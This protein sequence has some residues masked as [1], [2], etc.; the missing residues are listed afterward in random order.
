MDFIR[1]QLDRI[2]NALASIFFLLLITEGT[3]IA[4]FFKLDNGHGTLPSI[5]VYKRA[6]DLIVA[7]SRKYVNKGEVKTVSIPPS[8]ERAFYGVIRIRMEQG[9]ELRF[10]EAY[11]YPTL[12]RSIGGT[13]IIQ[14]RDMLDK[15]E[16]DEI[17]ERKNPYADNSTRVLSRNISYGD[18]R[19]RSLGNTDH[20]PPRSYT[21]PKNGSNPQ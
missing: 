16:R 3:L 4:M 5:K 20:S 11:W 13:S 17:L 8:L 21:V 6:F 1:E 15:A 19:R 14:L 10:T 2:L 7:R 12:W 9:V 18:I